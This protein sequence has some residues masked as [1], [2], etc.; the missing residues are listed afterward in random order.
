M[1]D[2]V[3]EI[4]AK[5]EELGASTGIDAYSGLTVK[6][7]G[8]GRVKIYDDYTS[9][10]GD[11]AAMLKALEGCERIKWEDDE[12]PDPLEQVLTAF[13]AIWA[14]LTDAGLET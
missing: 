10:K 4:N 8:N 9:G 11:A 7:L 14:A 1:K 13:N 6:D 3:Q 2:I 12:G 5:L